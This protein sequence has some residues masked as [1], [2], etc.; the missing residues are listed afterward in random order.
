MYR[1]ILSISD[2]P[3]TI[4]RLIQGTSPVQGLGN[5]T[6]PVFRT[7]NI[8]RLILRLRRKGNT[9]R[10]TN[11]CPSLKISSVIRFSDV[12][13]LI[14]RTG[15]ILGSGDEPGLV[16][17]RGDVDGVSGVS[18]GELRTGN[19]AHF[20]LVDGFRGVFWYVLGLVHRVVL[21][22]VVGMEQG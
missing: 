14:L 12:S 20:V 11:D 2:V 6:G 10:S 21:S 9:E 18:T 17:G 13:R 16:L 19:V 4:L 5:K 1:L 7:G 15:N 8:P 22:V 3:G